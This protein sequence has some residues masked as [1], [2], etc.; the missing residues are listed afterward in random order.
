MK[1]G[2]SD[3]GKEELEWNRVRDQLTTGLNSRPA[4]MSR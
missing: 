4:L 2:G 1:Y 3:K